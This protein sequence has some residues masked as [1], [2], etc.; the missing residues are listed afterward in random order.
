M[1]GCNARAQIRKTVNAADPPTVAIDSQLLGGIVVNPLLA[2]T[3]LTF[4]PA[5]T[6][7]LAAGDYVMDVELLMPDGTIVAT[8]IVDVEILPEVTRG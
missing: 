1:M 5:V 6:E 7:P 2:A 8:K 4:A 3:V